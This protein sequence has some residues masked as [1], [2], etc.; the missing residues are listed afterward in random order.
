MHDIDTLYWQLHM[1]VNCVLL[2]T[3]T[4]ILH[5][6][7]IFTPFYMNDGT[8]RVTHFSSTL[9]FRL[10]ILTTDY[11]FTSFYLIILLQNN[12]LVPTREFFVQSTLGM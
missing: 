5:F 12:P 3:Y 6:Y 11:F 8:A 4:F 9:P 1:E 10:D 2:S 7:M